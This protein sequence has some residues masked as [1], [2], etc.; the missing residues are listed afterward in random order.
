MEKDQGQVTALHGG[1]LC[2][3][4]ARAGCQ[5]ILREAKRGAKGAQGKRQV[6]R[7][8]GGGGTEAELEGF[9]CK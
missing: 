5:Q 7:A 3:T 1:D 4:V 6:A 2:L 9:L 8:R